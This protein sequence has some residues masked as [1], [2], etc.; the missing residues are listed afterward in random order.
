MVCSVRYGEWH[1]L[2]NIFRV[3]RLLN[4]KIQKFYMCSCMQYYYCIKVVRGNAG[5]IG[6]TG[7]FLC[8]YVF[9]PPSVHERSLLHTLQ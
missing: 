4:Q 9:Q 7:V 3:A 1:L 2:K 8:L 5:L 6:A